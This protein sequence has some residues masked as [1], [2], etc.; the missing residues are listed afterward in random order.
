MKTASRDITLDC[1][2]QQILDMEFSC[3]SVAGFDV[4]YIINS[5]MICY[6]RH[7]AL[8]NIDI[9]ARFI[10]AIKTICEY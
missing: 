2:S 8:G 6:Y 7:A 4:G 9:S 3:L 5:Y 10:E 1:S